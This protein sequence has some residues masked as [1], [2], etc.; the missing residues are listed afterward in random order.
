M[1]ETHKRAIAVAASAA[2][3]Y[4]AVDR[5]YRYARTRWGPADKNDSDW[6]CPGVGVGG[7][8]VGAG[9]AGYLLCGA[10][11]GS[12]SAGCPMMASPSGSDRVKLDLPSFA[13]ST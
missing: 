5:L 12:K 11:K 13:L 3:G 10:D 4:F 2:A 9:I 6:V 7:S 1:S 8:L